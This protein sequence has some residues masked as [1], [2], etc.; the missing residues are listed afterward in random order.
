MKVESLLFCAEYRAT[1][2]AVG[3]L[4]MKQGCNS[5]GDVGHVGGTGGGTML[6]APS[7]EDQG[8]VGVVGIPGA[9]VGSFHAVVVVVWF[10]HDGY[11]SASL[12]VVAV[13]NAVFHFVGD[14]RCGNLLHV[15]GIQHVGILLQEAYYSLLD[16]GCVE[17][18]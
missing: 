18:G 8:Y 1:D 7:H 3:C 6:D 15:A 5:G 14:A 4:N 11:A 9:M 13:D 2:V 16:L 12:T 17:T 10:Q